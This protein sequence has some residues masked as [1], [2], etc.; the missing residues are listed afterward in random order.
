MLSGVVCAAL[1]LM[2][3]S[4]G[5]VDFLIVLYA[6]NVFITFCLSQAGMV[7]H[8]WKERKKLGSW[9]RK[10]LINGFGLLLT[11][12]ILVSQ[13][14]LKF[15]EG[16]W[17]TLLITGSL[18]VVAITVKRFYFKTGKRLARLDHLM[19]G[20]TTAESDPPA[21]SGEGDSP[22]KRAPHFDRKGKTAVLLVS[23]FNG[24]G[25]H[26]L[27]NVQRVFGGTFKNWFFIEAG[28][29]DADRFKGVEGMEKLQAH[30][31]G[32]LARYVKFMRSEGF[33]AQGFST[34]GTDVADEICTLAETI[35]EKHPN[36]VFFGGQIVFPEDTFLSRLLFNHTTFAVQRRLHQRG[37]PFLV[38]P[39][40]VQ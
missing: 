24:T 13:V 14:I 29:L 25:L 30:V 18:V 23:G 40:R 8:W 17:I 15:G 32:D 37:I 5:S 26:T 36:A 35:Y 1:V 22:R 34:V 2:L 3:V 20:V 4:R 21:A 31:E 28:I 9:K 7:R 39:I 10:I 11:G 38:M 19:A 6:I 33:H 27:L 12:F 16:G